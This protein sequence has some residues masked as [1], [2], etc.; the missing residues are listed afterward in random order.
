MTLEY[1]DDISD[2]GRF[3]HAAG[4]KILRL[5]HHTPEESA[6][7]RGIIIQLASGTLQSFD[8]SSCTWV[9]SLNCR[10]L[11]AVSDND[12]GLVSDDSIHFTCQLTPIEWHHMADRIQPFCETSAN[13]YQWLCETS[14]PF[15][16]LYS[17]DGSW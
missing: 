11:F 4:E 2:N 5:Y 10:L 12:L 13:G 8:I 1:L 14:S 9:N 6:L 3:P 17:F 16:F 15:D 7:L